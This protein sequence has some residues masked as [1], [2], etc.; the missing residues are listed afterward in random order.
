MEADER[1]AEG[2]AAAD[3]PSAEESGETRFSIYDYLETDPEHR[4]LRRLPHL[5][6]LAVAVVWR[7]APREFAASAILQVAAGAGLAMQLLLLRSL[8]SELLGG[9]GNPEF[10]DVLPEIIGLSLVSGLIAFAN[11]LIDGQQR[12]LGALVAQHTADQLI[13][14]ATSVDLV[15]YESPRFHDRLQRAWVSATA[16]PTQLANGLI[17]IVGGLFAVAGIGFALLVVQP[18]FFAMIVGGF[19]PAWLATTRAGRL[20]YKLS[21]HQTERERRRSYLFAILTRKE[22]AQEIRAFD[23]GGFL[24]A[25]HRELYEANIAELRTV[26]RQ[27]LKLVSIGQFLT[28]IVSAAAIGMLVWFVTTD[29][30]SLAEAG[31]AAGAMVLLT[32]RLRGLAGSAAGLYEGS[33]YLEDYSSFVAVAPQLAAARPTLAAPERLDVVAAEGVTFTYPSRTE[34]SLVDASLE[35]NRGEVVALVGENGSGKTTFAKLLAGLYQPQDGAITWDGVDT[36]AIEPRS[37]HSRVAV[38][39]QDFVRWQLSALDNIAFGDHARVDDLDAVVRAAKAAG[40]HDE[41][42]GLERGYE[43]LLGPQFY[44]GSNLSGGQWQR[45]ALARAFFRDAPLVILDEPAASLDPRAEAALYASMGEL[46]SGRGVLLISHRFG[47]VRTANRIYVLDK[48]RVVEHGTHEELVA[49]DGRYAEL[50]R[51]QAKWYLD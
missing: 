45:I 20:V 3:E 51:L 36:S 10:G 7:A 42:A 25:R 24:G 16:R 17:G 50:F 40:V 39:F 11:I 31:S 34:P 15:T 13:D 22:E 29:R 28:A 19:I 1:P 35:L 30:V 14:M 26:I 6:R 47:S 46:F 41:L 12:I 38:I 49:L 33:L 43:T 27:R 44:G 32:G 9:T 4:R 23:L 2:D 18:L 8:L 21:V 48:G 5:L 37:A